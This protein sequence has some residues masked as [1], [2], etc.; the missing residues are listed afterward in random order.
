M[1]ENDGIKMTLKAH[2]ETDRWLK[3]EA[4]RIVREKKAVVVDTAD[5]RIVFVAGGEVDAM[6]A[7]MMAGVTWE[8]AT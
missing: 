1:A 3:Q 2:P 6:V 8:V 5:G 7:Q 4:Q